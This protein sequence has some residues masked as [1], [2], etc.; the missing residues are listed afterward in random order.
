[1]DPISRATTATPEV[2]GNRSAAR[3]WVAEFLMRGL[4]A[5]VGDDALYFADH[6]YSLTADRIETS[7][8]EQVCMDGSTRTCERRGKLGFQRHSRETSTSLGP[9]DC[10]QPCPPDPLEDLVEPLDEVLSRRKFSRLSSVRGAV[11]RSKKL[12]LSDRW[13]SRVSSTEIVRH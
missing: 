3:A 12:C 10:S 13:P 7:V 9:T 1:M 8:E 2:A 4:L 11:Y 5:F 6:A